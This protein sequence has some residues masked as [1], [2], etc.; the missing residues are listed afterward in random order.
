MTKLF[1]LTGLLA[2]C[3]YNMQRTWV[4]VYPSTLRISKQCEMKTCSRI[5]KIGILRGFHFRLSL[6]NLHF[7]E[8]FV[9]LL[10]KVRK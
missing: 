4:C 2:D 6:P 3:V 7:L 9:E 10:T 8:V 5:P 1:Y